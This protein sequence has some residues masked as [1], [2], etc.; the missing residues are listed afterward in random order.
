[1]SKKLRKFLLDEVERMYADAESTAAAYGDAFNTDGDFVDNVNAA[2]DFRAIE[3][4]E[5]TV[6]TAL[7]LPKPYRGIML[8]RLALFFEDN[9]NYKE[10][11]CP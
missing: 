5:D 10:K 8:R 11:W 1:M 7:A 9:P 2:A 4:F 3:V 6:W